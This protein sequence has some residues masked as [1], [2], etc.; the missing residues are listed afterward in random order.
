MYYNRYHPQQRRYGSFHRQQ[1]SYCGLCRTGIDCGYI[2]LWLQRYW[3][4]DKTDD[5]RRVLSDARV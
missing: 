1:T 3:V 4:Y 2:Y 5:L